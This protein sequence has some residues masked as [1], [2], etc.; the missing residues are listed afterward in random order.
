MSTAVGTVRLSRRW[1]AGEDGGFTADAA[2]GVDG[3]LSPGVRRLASFAGAGKPFAK[4]AATL[5]ELSGIDLGEE[6]VRGATHAVARE[7]R[8]G[9]P[10]RPDAARFAGAE[11]ELEVAIDAGKVNTPDGWRD[12]KIAVVAARPAGEPAAPGDWDTRE[13]PPPA[14][15]AVVAE[16]EEA[17][18]FATR[19]RAETDR[20][21]AT[22]A[23]AASALGDGAEWIWALV[24][25]VLP[26][27]DGTLDVYHALL[28]VAAAAD[29]VWGKGTAAAKAGLEAGRKALLAGGKA[30]VERWA[31]EAFAHAPGAAAQEAL[32]EAAAYFAKHP[33]RLDYARRLA[34]GRSI[35]SGMVEGAVKQLVN[36]RFK[37]TGAAKWLPGNVGPL[38]ELAAFVDSP[39]WHSYWCAA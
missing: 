34:E 29:A 26:Q 31:G 36:L 16:V 2:L 9:R 10:A 17:E 35:G 22:A 8:A 6:T 38:V 37:T 7:A 25:L 18:D 33:G 14:F 28:Y 3:F 13:L 5:K 23:E 21:G 24:A 27:A 15:R 32:L 30:G 4:A 20:L 19:V 39:E 11:G 12:V 1:F